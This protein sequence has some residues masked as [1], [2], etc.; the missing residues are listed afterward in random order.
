VFDQGNCTLMGP[1]EQLSR[2]KELLEAWG[3]KVNLIG[4]EARGN[5]DAHIEEAER[6]A[7]FLE[8]HGEV[9][10]VGSGGGLPAIP[11]AIRA[12]Q[13]RFHLVESDRRKWAFLKFAVRECALNCAVL[14]DR[15]QNLRFPPEQRFDLVTSRAVG[16]VEEW[17][18]YVV[19]WLSPFGR[20]ALFQTSPDFP[21]VASLMP[22]TTYRLP[23]SASHFLVVLSVP[24]ET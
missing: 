6:A 15:L 16:H 17:A 24:R 3:R 8:P 19:P 18:P 12:P 5:I 7:E 10:D 13:A 1:A 21:A 11:M 22:Q 20:I 23:R 4:P 9:L 14:G 2:Y